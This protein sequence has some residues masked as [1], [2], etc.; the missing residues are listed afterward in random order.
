[1]ES[2]EFFALKE[3]KTK[4]EEV[5]TW[6]H[7]KGCMMLKDNLTCSNLPYACRKNSQ[8]CSIDHYSIGTCSTNHAANGDKSAANCSIFQETKDCRYESKLGTRCVEI[9]TSGLISKPDCF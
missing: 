1:M 7:K 6:G 9:L 4:M 8:V 3:P 5:L 2:M